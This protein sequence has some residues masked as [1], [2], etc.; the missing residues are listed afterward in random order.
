MDR[1]NSAHFEEMLR[2]VKYVY[3]TREL[4]LE[5]KTKVSE[6]WELVTF[7]DSDW[8]GDKDDRKSINGYAIFFMG[9]LIGWGSRG[10]KVVALS[11]TEAEYISTSELVKQII[12][13][14]QI[15]DFFS[16]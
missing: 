5:L 16:R 15:L 3:D 13:V 6:I 2:V 1:G 10:Q 11:S 9:C 12:N 14:K 8:G 4:S 7:S